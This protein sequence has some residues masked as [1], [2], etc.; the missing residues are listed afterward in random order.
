MLVVTGQALVVGTALTR[1]VG[2]AGA[3]VIAATD[4]TEE[5]LCH[6]DEIV[7]TAATQLVRVSVA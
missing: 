4:G 2:T 6:A 7:T 3:L 1:S 5:V